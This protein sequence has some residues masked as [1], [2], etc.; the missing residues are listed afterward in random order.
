MALSEKAAGL[1]ASETLTITKKVRELKDAGIDVI[2]LTLGEPD[3]NTPLH[4]REA[5]KQAIDDGFTHY[6]P[7]AGIPE[8]RKAI[9]EKLVRENGLTQFGPQNIV[10]SNGA[11]QSIYN[12]FLAMVNPGEEVIIPAPYWVSY[13]GIA[14]LAEAKSVIL[15]AGVER[16]YKMD[17]EAID[18]AINPNTKLIIFS[19]P[20]NPTGTMYTHEELHEIAKVLAKH[21]HV[22]IISDEI[23]EHLV[24]EKPHVSIGIFPEVADQ[25]IVV[26]GFSKGFAMT[27]WRLGYAA[28]PLAI[29]EL[30][31]KLQGQST[32][33]ANSITQKAAL[34]ALSGDLG[35][36]LA[37]RDAFRLRKEMV[38][39]MLAAIP[40]VKALDP[41]GAFY[42]YPDLSAFFGK[43][44]P[45]GKRIDDIEQLCLY[46]MEEGGVALIPGTAFG[47]TKEVRIS[48]AYEKSLLEE[49][50][51]RLSV[52]L[53]KLQ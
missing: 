51:R 36:V 29:A 45:T 31:E 37:M 11:K 9:A 12:L 26:N 18:K 14:D 21:P 23:Y 22:Y 13:K 33:G 20:C 38:H 34:A 2:G 35:P 27:G 41:D 44:S 50:I 1:P 48:Y 32:S 46:L 40:G 24:F 25:V 39:D 49:A 3:F 19:S 28:A 5:A 47:T 30:S 15:P 7:V 8:L 4:I 43:S 10:V 6:T 53:R 42:F 52:A 16:E 17:P